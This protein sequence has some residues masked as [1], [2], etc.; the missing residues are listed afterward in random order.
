MSELGH[1]EI[2]Q[3]SSRVVSSLASTVAPTLGPSSVDQIVVG[4][5]G[6]VLI[7]NSGY[8]ILKSVNIEGPIGKFVLTCTKKLTRCAAMGVQLMSLCWMGC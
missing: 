2:L 7:T 3:L 5:G 4:H 6:D 8:S 1:F